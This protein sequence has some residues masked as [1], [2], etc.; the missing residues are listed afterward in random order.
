MNGEVTILLVMLLA[1]GKGR[2]VKR[3]NLIHL[4]NIGI[5]SFFLVSQQKK[6]AKSMIVWEDGGHLACWFIQTY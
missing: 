4:D 2:E 5:S 6:K 1:F 3:V